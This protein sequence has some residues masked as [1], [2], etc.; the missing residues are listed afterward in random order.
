[1]IA[2]RAREISRSTD[3]VILE[4]SRMQ[5]RPHVRPWI[6]SV[7][8]TTQNAHSTMRSRPGKS[9]GRAKAVARVTRPRMPLQD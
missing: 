9:G 3:A 4:S 1:M 7:P 2:T 6:T 8:S 5:Q